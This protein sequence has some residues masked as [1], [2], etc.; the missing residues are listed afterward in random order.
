MRTSRQVIETLIN[1]TIDQI[2]MDLR[3][4]QRGNSYGKYYLYHRK[5]IAYGDETMVPFVVIGALGGGNDSGYDIKDWELVFIGINGSI[6]FDSCAN[7]DEIRHFLIRSFQ[8]LPILNPYMDYSKLE[9][10]ESIQ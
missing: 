2:I 8:K 7:D 1:N 5:E 9:L 10:E 4:K 3:S 6:C